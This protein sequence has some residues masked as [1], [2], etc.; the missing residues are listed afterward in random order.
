MR[1][2]S[3]HE[4]GREARKWRSFREARKWAQSLGLLSER[5][6]RE[7]RKRGLPAGIPTNPNRTYAK[8]WQGWGNWLRNDKPVSRESRFRS[9]AEASKWA[10]RNGIRSKSDWL[11]LVAAGKKPADIPSNL[12]KKYQADWTSFGDFCGSGFVAWERRRWARYDIARRWAS[13]H[14]IATKDEW[15]AAAAAGLLPDNIPRSLPQV[16]KDQWKGWREFLGQPIRGGSSLVESIIAFELAHFVVVDDM[17][18][19]IQVG[20]NRRKRVDVVLAEARAIVE[21]DGAHWHRGSV[22]KDRAD[23]AA[24]RR[25]GWRVVRIR[26]RPLRK[27]SGDDIVV[28]PHDSIHHR[29]SLVL[30]HLSDLGLLRRSQRRR[31]AK[32]TSSGRLYASRSE[33]VKVT[34]WQSFEDA[35]RWARSLKL[36]SETEWRAYKRNTGMPSNIPS[37][38]NLVY[39]MQWQG[40][41]DW[42]GTG[43]VY[44]KPGQWLSF[45]RARRW[46]RASGIRMAREWGRLGARH[47]LPIG[48]PSDP[49]SVY[50]TQW[51]SWPDWL[52]LNVG[53]GH[54]K[55]C[56]S[57][58][59]AR[60][61][62][63][64]RR[65]LTVS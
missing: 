55:E 62:A 7:R 15:E 27:I 6:W 26:E 52:G 31:V 58:T 43:N 36:S 13:E 34:G 3:P 18:R 51:T 19:S 61:W 4:R 38:P 22:A 10:K 17:V 8:E 28:S 54:R 49:R 39:P 35:R 2:I 41:G 16:Y 11:R 46:A 59:R 63:R 48:I 40:W 65:L 64:S 21:Y 53:K 56:Q 29:A 37:S 44:V 45:D 42:L 47:K 33:L 20:H 50:R 57:F 24:L 14:R 25:V 32:Y 9:Y 1:R 5:E 30:N 60:R 12:E 23:N